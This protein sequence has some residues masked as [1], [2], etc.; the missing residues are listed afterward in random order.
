MRHVAGDV[1]RA[2]GVERRRRRGRAPGTSAAIRPAA[3]DE[4]GGRRDVVDEQ[5]LAALRST[6]PTSSSH[7]GRAVGHRQARTRR[8]RRRRRRPRR[9]RRASSA[10]AGTTTSTSAPSGASATRTS[11]QPSVGALDDADGQVVEQLVGDDDPGKVT[12]G[13]SSRLVTIGPMPATGSGASSGSSPAIT[14]PSTSSAGSRVRRS[15]CVGTQRGRALD[16]HVAQRRRARRARP[17]RTSTRTVLAPRRPRRRRTDRGAPAAS[18]APSSGGR[19][20]APNS[21]PTSGLVTKSRP[22]RPAPRPEREEAAV[23]P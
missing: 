14:G 17:R 3:R 19:R 7:R 15:R 4:L 20:S 6:R 23:R 9:P 12:A 10:G 18:H 5:D 21:G 1:L 8:D 13:S 2:G 16:E 11:D 22:A